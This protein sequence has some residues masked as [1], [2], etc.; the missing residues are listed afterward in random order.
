M[1][2]SNGYRSISPIVE[3]RERLLPSSP[4]VTNLAQSALDYR[5]MDGIDAARAWSSQPR[6]C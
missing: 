6:A 1:L 5:W 3:L 4:R 2:S